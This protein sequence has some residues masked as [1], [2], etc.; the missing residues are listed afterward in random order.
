MVMASRIHSIIDREVA[1]DQI[2]SALYS[3]LLTRTTAVNPD[4][5]RN[6]S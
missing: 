1:A 6:A 3:R 2:V 5:L 4:V